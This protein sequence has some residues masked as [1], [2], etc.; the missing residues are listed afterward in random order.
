[1]FFFFL[2]PFWLAKAARTG[3]APPFRRDRSHQDCRPTIGTSSP[4]SFNERERV[5]LPL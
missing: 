5:F 1:M 4:L 2:Y 3:L